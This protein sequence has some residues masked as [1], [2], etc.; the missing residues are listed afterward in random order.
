MQRR[1]INLFRDGI[2]NP[3][4]PL[5][6]RLVAADPVKLRISLEHMEKGIHG[7]IRNHAVFG[8]LVV[9]DLMKFPVE[10]L[11]IAYLV[12]TPLL[13]DVKQLHGRCQRALIL[14]RIIIGREGVNRKRLIVSMLRCILRRTVIIHRP[15]NASLFLIHTKLLHEFV[16]VPRFQ[17]KRFILKRH[18]SVCKKPCNTAV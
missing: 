9:F 15:V 3:H 10:S 7:L 5:F 17:K 16:T 18:V 13:D 14:R 8:E 6:H 12:H 1:I 11:L 4:K 2:Q